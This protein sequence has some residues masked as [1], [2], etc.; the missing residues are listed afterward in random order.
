MRHVLRGVRYHG[1]KFGVRPHVLW[2]PDTFGYSAAFPQIMKLSGL[3]VFV[4]HKMSW[5]DTNRFPNETFFWQGIDGTRAPTYFLTT[6]PMES[7]SIGTTYCPNLNASQVMG[8]WRRYAQKATN[9]ELFLVYGFG[10]G[11]GG[12]TREMLE[13]IRRMQR[14]IPGCPHVEQG[15]MGPFLERVVNRMEKSPGDYPTWVGELYLEFHRGTFTSVA[16]VKRNNRRAEA[17]LREL[18][19]LASLAWIRAGAPYPTQ[20]LAELWDLALLNQF[21]DIL[22]G[23]SI[24]L[25]FDDSDRDYAS[26]FARAESLQQKLAGA[27]AGDGEML[28]LNPFGCARGG[29]ITA[30]SEAAVA[31]AGKPSQTVFSADG[32]KAEAVPLDPV[33]ALGAV[34]INLV[35]ATAASGS[36]DL[37]VAVNRLENRNIRAE[38]DQNGRLTSVFDKKTERECLL[39]GALGNR[40]QAYR[41]LPAQF[42][43]WDIDNNYEDQ[44]WEIDALVSAEVVE[45]GPYRAAIRLEWAYEASR[46]VQIVSL[47]EKSGILAFDTFIDWHENNTLVKTAFPLAVRTTQTRAEIQFGH[48]ARPTHT[49]TSWDQARFEAPMQRWVE[50]SEPGFGVAF[51]NDCKYGYDAKDTTLRLTLLRSP[52]YPWPQADQG[53]HRFRYGMMVHHGLAET[54]VSAKAEAFN[55]PLT[56]IAGSGA[57]KNADL[58]SLVAS[59]NPAIVIEAVKRAEDS[60]AL[61]VRLWERDGAQQSTRLML[62]P[63]FVTAAETDLLEDN[64]RLLE[65]ADNALMLGFTP[66]EIK[67]LK[68]RRAGSA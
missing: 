22:P 60:D 33:P 47:E 7:T 14:G 11:G 40:I 5:N 41:D 54:G 44:V 12:P 63:A 65:I 62:S 36:G 53:E 1:E 39:D 37:Q 51:F 26:F 46:I 17:M 8:T 38:F 43:A 10:D 57:P 32:R 21:H 24:G 31:I 23:S 48:V 15:F 45:T 55:H 52:T 59:E 61:I 35:T 34:R 66:F 68:L 29:L 67:T 2:L 27:L 49:N 50:L 3:S 42:D 58:A 18:E 30:Q 6:Q 16:K 20:E 64:V 56:L 9:D 25:V 4:T 28:V 13:H 19:A